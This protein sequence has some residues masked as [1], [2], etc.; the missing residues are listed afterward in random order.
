MPASWYLAS[1]SGLLEL[2][3]SASAGAYSFGTISHDGVTVTVNGTP[4]VNRWFDQAATPTP[5]WGA[6]ST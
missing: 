3:A 6:R 4:V 2:P 1:W 5:V